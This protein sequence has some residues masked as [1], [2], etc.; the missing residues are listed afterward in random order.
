MRPQGRDSNNNHTHYEHTGGDTNTQTHYERTG[1]DSNNQTHYET[2]GGD[3]NTQTHYEPTGARKKNK[4]THIM[5]PQ[6]VITTI[7]KLTM[8]PQGREKK[9]IKLTLGAHRGDNNNETH[10]E[11]TGARQQQSTRQDPNAVCAHRG[12][13]ATTTKHTMNTQGPI[14]TPKRSMSPQ[15]VVTTIKLIMNPQG[16]GKKQSN[17]L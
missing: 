14:T 6:V 8:N 2:A 12:A 3:E 1:G 7:I 15:G 17:T 9:T 10:Y 13:T 11:T 16:H 5:S 4:Q